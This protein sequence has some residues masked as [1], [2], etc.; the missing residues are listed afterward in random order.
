MSKKTNGPTRTRGARAAVR[1]LRPTTMVDRDAATDADEALSARAAKG[2]ATR[3]PLR[4]RAFRLLTKVFAGVLIYAL[5]VATATNGLPF[6]AAFLA[7]SAGITD[8]TRVD[9]TVAVWLIPLLFLSGMVFYAEVKLIPV[10]WRYF[11]RVAERAASWPFMM[12]KQQ[13]DEKNDLGAASGD[14]E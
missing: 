2:P 1:S 14:V 9:V 7:N 12:S 11:G 3:A 13:L 5:L 10:V 6:I 8:K 4:L